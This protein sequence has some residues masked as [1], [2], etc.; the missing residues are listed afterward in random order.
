M[1]VLGWLPA[2][3]PRLVDAARRGLRRLTLRHPHGARRLPV[4]RA[5]AR[6]GDFFGPLASRFAQG[7][8]DYYDFALPFQPP[9]APLHARRRP[10]RDLRGLPPVGL[11]V[12][13]RR[14]TAAALT[15]L[16]WAAWP[17]TL[18]TGPGDLQRGAVLAGV[19]LLLAGARPVRAA[20]RASASRVAAVLVAASLGVSRRQRWP[21][22]SS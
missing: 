19:L 5:A 8:G 20:A 22:A 4:R 2:L 1:A 14:P 13:A 9:R 17:M 21:R 7:I 6:P 18:F 15:L 3:L 10:A 11:C 12:A 16:V